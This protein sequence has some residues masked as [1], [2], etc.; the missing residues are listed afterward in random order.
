SSNAKSLEWHCA[1]LGSS[2]S[3]TANAVPCYE[4]WNYIC[5]LN[6]GESVGANPSLKEDS[7]DNRR[8]G[9][10]TRTA[11]PSR[12]PMTSA[13]WG[14]GE[15]R[16]ETSDQETRRREQEEIRRRYEEQRQ[17][18]LQEQADRARQEFNE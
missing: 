13:T 1:A 4:E 17:R 9:R 14:Y 10:F 11:E 5:L 2:E 12:R 8:D 16:E 15:S 3:Y 7:S 6:R 18:M